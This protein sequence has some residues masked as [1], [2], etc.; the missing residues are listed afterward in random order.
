MKDLIKGLWVTTKTGFSE[1]SW[2][3]TILTGGVV[4]SEYLGIVGPA[5]VIFTLGFFYFIGH[6][7]KKL[8]R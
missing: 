6:A 1:A 2:F 4:I 3:I 5:A 8:M 7:H